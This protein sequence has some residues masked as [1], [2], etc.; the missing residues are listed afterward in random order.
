MLKVLLFSILREIDMI[1]VRVSVG[2][3]SHFWRKAT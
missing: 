2:K 1:L 3:Q